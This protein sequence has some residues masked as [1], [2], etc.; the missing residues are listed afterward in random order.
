MDLVLAKKYQ[1]ARVGGR[2]TKDL[3]TLVREVKTS[4][5]YVEQKNEVSETSGVMFEIDEVATKRLNSKIEQ[6]IKSRAERE[7]L[8]KKTNVKALADAL[9][10][11]TNN[12]T[13]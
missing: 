3:K 5:D 11:S 4:R 12:K 6:Q 10:S 9:S 2:Y 1:L 8:E 7:E 13:R